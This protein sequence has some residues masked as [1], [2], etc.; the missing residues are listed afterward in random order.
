VLQEIKLGSAT[1]WGGSIM[2]KQLPWLKLEITPLMNIETLELEY[3]PEKSGVYVM[4]SDHT[5]Y[6]YPWS[7]SNGNSKVYYIGKAKNLRKRLATH[8]RYCT[9][10]ITKP[11]LRYKYYYPRYEYAA[12]HGCNVGWILSKTPKK[13]ENELLVAFAGYYG[14]KPVANGQSGW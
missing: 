11:D 8:K 4:V 9:E 2:S 13:T 1:K 7:G 14:A 5:E 3:I 6:V 10:A 12:H